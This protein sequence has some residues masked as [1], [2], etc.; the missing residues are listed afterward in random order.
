MAQNQQQRFQQ[1][2]DETLRRNHN[3]EMKRQSEYYYQ[4]RFREMHE[5]RLR[6]MKEKESVSQ[7]I[8]VSSPIEIDFTQSIQCI[9]FEGL[10]CQEHWG[11]WSDADILKIKFETSLPKSFTITLFGRSYGPNEHKD[12][13][14]TVGQETTFFR[15]PYRKFDKAVLNFNNNT[16]AEKTISIKIPQPMSPQQWGENSDTRLLGI[17]LVKIVIQERK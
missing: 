13:Y 11:R 6:E 16:S 3:A 14:A 5:Q 7:V 17:A 2:A 9:E 8:Q 12:F 1:M 15:L 10:S 4:Q